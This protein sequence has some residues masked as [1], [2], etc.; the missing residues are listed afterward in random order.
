MLL[1]GSLLLLHLTRLLLLLL[2]LLELSLYVCCVLRVRVCAC[3]IKKK[4]DP[5]TSLLTGFLILAKKGLQKL[6][7]QRILE[8]EIRKGKARTIAQETQ[9]KDMQSLWQS[10]KDLFGVEIK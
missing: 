6:E 10:R 5:H 9:F 7:D 8:L 3:V 1:V 4:L 2:L